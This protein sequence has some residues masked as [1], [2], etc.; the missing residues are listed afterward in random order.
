MFVLVAVAEMCVPCCI[1]SL[2]EGLIRSSGRWDGLFA[3]QAFHSHPIV[4]QVHLIMIQRLC[5][6]PMYKCIM[7][8]TTPWQEKEHTRKRV[9]TLKSEPPCVSTSTN[10]NISSSWEKNIAFVAARFLQFWFIRFRSI[11]ICS[12][13]FLKKV[14]CYL[15]IAA[16][17]IH[18]W[19]I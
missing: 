3:I 19:S 2:A 18:P 11:Q 4:I 8:G 1:C 16:I 14:G 10:Y 15:N 5:C 12:G 17:S 9:Q 6:V 13:H 7:W